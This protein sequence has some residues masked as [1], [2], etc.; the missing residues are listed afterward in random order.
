MELVQ[1]HTSLEAIRRLNASEGPASNIFEPKFAAR[2]QAEQ[3]QETI[4]NVYRDQ[5]SAIALSQLCRCLVFIGTIMMEVEEE[6]DGDV[7]VRRA[8]QVLEW[9]IS[10]NLP[11]ATAVRG[12]SALP[13]EGILEVTKVPEFETGYA[14]SGVCFMAVHNA[15]GLYLSRVNP[16][17][18]GT[19]LKRAED[20]YMRWDAWAVQQPVRCSIS[21]ISFGENGM[22]D[23]SCIAADR[24]DVSL[25]CYDM[26]CCMTTTLYFIAQL[27]TVRQDKEAASEYCYRTL[28][29]QLCNMQEFDPKSWAENALA[30]GD[31]YSSCF[32]Y[33]RA[34]HCIEAGRTIMPDGNDP[35]EAKGCVAWSFGRFFLH[36]LQ[37]YGDLFVRNGQPSADAIENAD[38]EW[39]P[40]PGIAPVEPHA[41]IQTFEDSRMCFKEG[42]RWLTEARNCRPFELRCTD[43]VAIST[44]MV[45]LYG[46][47]EVFE[48]NRS[49][50]IAMIQR[51]IELLE[52]FP[53][54][55][56]FNAYPT[57]IRQLLYDI[58]TLYENQVHL[59]RDQRR[60]PKKGEKPLRDA[61]FNCL[62]AKAVDCYQRFIETWR[63]PTTNVLPDVLEEESRLPFLQARMRLASLCLQYASATPKDEY[64]RIGK[65]TEAFQGAIGFYEAN[66]LPSD[67]ADSMSV[68]IERTREMLTLL[69][70]K[71][72][73]IW[74]V[75]QKMSA[76]A[77]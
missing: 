67:I 24:I 76:G 22:L 17:H 38:S 58:G 20:F 70:I 40:F 68:E 27:Y 14:H 1:F 53:S 9:C 59:R 16:T 51:Q 39:L 72:Q 62:V 19:L 34:C 2:C 77:S 5:P 23:V 32:Q 46:A 31:F 56:S 37:H 47:L 73:E 26:H 33:D 54:Q 52:P 61:D 25:C 13:L 45:Q 35:D 41:P 74:K 29:Y 3:L 64:D 21:D 48:A 57:M 6:D 18:A 44:N 7:E 71:Q 10:G 43:H 28:Y 12:V 36:R 66:P 15:L 55:L 4:L 42:M 30:L 60:A 75:Y 49:R 65:A 8:Y 11:D 63:N 69:P 50:R